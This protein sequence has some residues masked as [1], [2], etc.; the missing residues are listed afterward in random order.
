[1]GWLIIVFVLL[2]LIV[3]LKMVHF[4]H[5]IILAIMVVLI[6]FF[7]ITF[8]TVA[9]NNA[10]TLDNAAGFFEASKIYFSWLGQ[11]FGNFKSLVGNAV[12]MDWLPEGTNATT[13]FRG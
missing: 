12:R 3:L 10:I 11:A 6:L 7:Y 13:I 5:R 4:K 8:A 1:M 2:T 9:S